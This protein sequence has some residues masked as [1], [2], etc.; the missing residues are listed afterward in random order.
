MWAHPPHFF[1][2]LTGHISHQSWWTAAWRGSGIWDAQGLLVWNWSLSQWTV[3]L[4]EAKHTD[5]QRERERER[6]TSAVWQLLWSDVLQVTHKKWEHLT[7]RKHNSSCR[8]TPH[9]GGP[10]NQEQTPRNVSN[11]KI[12]NHLDQWFPAKGTSITPKGG[13]L[14][15]QLPGGNVERL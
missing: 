15:L 8:L 1:F 4:L 10:A 11:K 6:E 2:F 5:R 13:N 12:K 7:V 9:I 14:T 3:F